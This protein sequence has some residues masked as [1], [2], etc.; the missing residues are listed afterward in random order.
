MNHD[1]DLQTKTVETEENGF[2]TK[3]WNSMSW[4]NWIFVFGGIFLF[5]IILCCT[6]AWVFYKVRQ[7]THESNS[8][9]AMD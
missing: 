9:F 5:I 2:F 1:A 6:C 4:L 8:F 7:N 3:M